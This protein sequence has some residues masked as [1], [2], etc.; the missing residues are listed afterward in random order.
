MET[1]TQTDINAPH[2]NEL[3]LDSEVRVF[4]YELLYSLID[5]QTLHFNENL[6]R[7]DDGLF[8][9]SCLCQLFVCYGMRMKLL[10]MSYGLNGVWS[11][12]NCGYDELLQIC[13]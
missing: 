6:H 11:R 10:K 12:K 1:E 4:R 13:T 5:L 2:T 9:C 8:A 3:A 7:L